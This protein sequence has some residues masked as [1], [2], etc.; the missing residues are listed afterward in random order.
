MILRKLVGFRSL[1]A[2]LV[3]FLTGCAENYPQSTLAPKSGFTRMIDQLFMTT[4]WWAV[5]IFVLVEGALIFAIIKFR[6]KP[7][8]PEPK[9]THGNTLVEVVWTI[10]PA[11]ILAI[12]AVPTIQTIFRIAEVPEHALTIEVIGHQWW[13]EF[14]Y[15]DKQIVT[16]NE[17]HVPVGKMVALKI[18]S[19]DVIHSFWLP[20]LT[21]KRDAFPR[22]YTTLWFTAEEAAEYTGQ[23]AEFCGVQHALMGFKVFADEPEVFEQWVANEKIGSPMVNGGV[24][25]QD[26]TAPAG[27]PIPAEVIERGEAIFLSAG[28]IGCHAMVGTPTAGVMAMVGPNLSHVGSRTTLV[29]N[30]MPNTDENL[31][32]WLRHPQELKVGSLMK[33][34]REL[35][36]EEIQALVAY[37]QAHK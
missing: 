11:I 18:T 34:P 4:V 16:A 36:E 9:Q 6:G 21:A 31:A 20:Q 27:T 8:D 28:C 25:V 15:P 29:A 12:I 5:V 2:I 13:W 33:L 3:L 1:L 32:R 10:V 24:V 35:T 23:C 22:R 37:L 17:M 19:A 26:S 30:L 7:D 14:R